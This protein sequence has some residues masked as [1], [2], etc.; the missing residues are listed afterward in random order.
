MTTAT[1]ESDHQTPLKRGTWSP[2]EDEKL[3]AYINRYG[4]WNWN[5]M[6]KAAGLSRS[7]KS[8]RL[9]WMNYLRPNI[10]RGNFT[11]E[12]EETIINLHKTL[13][14]RWS[15][16]AA[17]LPGRTDNE[18]KNHWHTHLRKLLNNNATAGLQMSKYAADV[19][20]SM[21]SKPSNANSFASSSYQI[22]EE[23]IGSAELPRELLV[24]SMEQSSSTSIN[25][26][27]KN[28]ENRMREVGT[29]EYQS[30]W[31]QP[32]STEELEIVENY[33]TTDTNQIWLQESVCP[34]ATRS[35]A[36]ND[37]WMNY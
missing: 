3:I 16:I 4:I 14:N 33:G 11:K 24:S 35:D 26:D 30:L 18:V 5:A 19:S 17:R 27:S 15:A 28:E 31:G 25:P 29:G 23:N 6:P 2:E 37:F 1:S 10:K 13:G 9:R 8:C 12:E 32:F 36:G 21:S 20:L 22:I 7:G 34:R